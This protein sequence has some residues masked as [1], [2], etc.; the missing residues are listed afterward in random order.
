MF[1]NEWYV[2]IFLAF[3]YNILFLHKGKK[4]KSKAPKIQRLITPDR[5]RRKRHRMLLKRR[6]YAASKAAADEYKKLLAKR[7]KVG[8]VLKACLHKGLFGFVSISSHDL[9]ILSY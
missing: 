2:Q 8:N 6:R 9:F 5:L 4:P 7:Q 1:T 3:F